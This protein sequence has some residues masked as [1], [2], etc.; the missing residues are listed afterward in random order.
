MIFKLGFAMFFV[1][2]IA[3]L[4]SCNETSVSHIAQTAVTDLQPMPFDTLR[5]VNF[6]SQG[7][8][9]WDQAT[10][11]WYETRYFGECLKAN[12]F[13]LDCSDCTNIGLNLALKVDSIGKILEITVLSTKIYCS[14]HSEEE[15]TQVKECMLQTF[16]DVLLSAPFQGKI[17]IVYVGRVPMC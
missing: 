16:S 7:R 6:G 11:D 2:L 12:N 8:K 15:E 1:V 10:K 3:C 13:Q 14:K 4:A 5:M 9:A 17:L